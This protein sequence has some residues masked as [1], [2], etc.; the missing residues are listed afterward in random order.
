MNQNGSYKPFNS[1]LIYTILLFPI[2]AI[3]HTGM[4]EPISFI[5]GMEHPI[6]G[7]D[8]ILAMIAV[9][10]LAVQMGGS[11]L[12]AMPTAFVSVMIIGGILGALQIYV[13][14]IETGIIA[15]VLIL[16]IIIATSARFSVLASVLIVGFF[17][18][19]HGVAHGMEMPINSYAMAYGA[20][21]ALATATLHGIGIAMGMSLNKLQMI[22]LQRWAGG[23]ITLGGIY[24]II[25]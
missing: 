8:H 7:I 23:M 9:G 20:G 15:S 25:A 6:S 5:A 21:F 16:G 1:I 3:A 18:I 17:A 19:F 4:I 14:F 11:A 12:W 2:T 13:P 22:N 24:L 10:F